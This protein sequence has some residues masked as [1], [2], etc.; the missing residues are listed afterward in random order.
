[1]IKDASLH[2]HVHSWLV[3]RHWLPATG[4]RPLHSLRA[5]PLRARNSAFATFGLAVPVAPRVFY[6]LRSAPSGYFLKPSAGDYAPARL[7]AGF[8]TLR[9]RTAVCVRRFAGRFAFSGQV[10]AAARFHPF[11]VRSVVPCRASLLLCGGVT[12]RLAGAWRLT[13]QSRGDPRPALLH[14]GGA[15]APSRVPRS[16]RSR[17][18]FRPGF[19]ES[20]RGQARVLFYRLSAAFRTASAPLRHPTNCAL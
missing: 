11:V 18:A 7:T 8:A 6:R 12:L 10:L 14:P 4:R 2:G 13:R 17:P 9:V 20:G 16:L 3:A 5:S 15:P 19:G 1:M